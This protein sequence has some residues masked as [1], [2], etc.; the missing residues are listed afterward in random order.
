[1]KRLSTLA[2]AVVAL[3]IAPIQANATIISYEFTG[4]VRLIPTGI[5]APY[6]LESSSGIFSYDTSWETVG[7]VPSGSGERE[8][9]VADNQNW[10]FSLSVGDFTFDS[11]PKNSTSQPNLTV[12]DNGTFSDPIFNQVWDQFSYNY[13]DQNFS[14]Q[15]SLSEYLI[16]PE[17]PDVFRSTDIPVELMLDDFNAPLVVL[18]VGGSRLR[19]E[20]DSLTPVAVP[21]PGTLALFGIGLAGMGLSRRRKQLT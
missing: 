18:S 19:L 11:S 17:I 21:E 8:T 4:E 15:I 6:Y 16:Q 7:M 10:S 1:M 3:L 5:F 20:L 13:T 9:Y 14:W 12:Q 2:V